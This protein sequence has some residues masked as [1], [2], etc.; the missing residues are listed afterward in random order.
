MK[1]NQGKINFSYGADQ[2]KPTQY[3]L[4]GRIAKATTELSQALRRGQ[5]HHYV[6]KG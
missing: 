1:R 2:D 4:D 3:S 6:L 5:D